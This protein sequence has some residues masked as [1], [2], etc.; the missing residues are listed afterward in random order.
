MKNK[1]WSIQTL[2][3]RLKNYKLLLLKAKTEEDKLNI[4]KTIKSYEQFIS[5]LTVPYQSYNYQ[6]IK[7]LDNAKKNE[8]VETLPIIIEAN[9]F[10]L[11]EN[12]LLPSELFSINTS[13]ENILKVTRSFY[14]TI[15]SIYKELYDEYYD[16]NAIYINFFNNY[17][18]S[19]CGNI[20]RP[21]GAKEC[22]ININMFNNPYD[23]AT[24][25]HEHSHAIAA[26]IYEDHID[27]PFLNE[28]ESILFELIYLDTLD[29]SEYKPE[30]IKNVKDVTI[31]MYNRTLNSIDS[32]NIT[33][34]KNV[35]DVVRAKRIIQEKYS[36]DESLSNDI[37]NTPL[38]N[39]INY[40]LSYLIAIE[41]FYIYK[42]C[43]I[44][45]LNILEEIIRIDSDEEDIILKYLQDLGIIPGNNFKRFFKDYL[46]IKGTKL[47]I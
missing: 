41:L 23:I 20:I 12:L 7:K 47:S 2:K 44:K 43:D 11:S 6:Y 33:T 38:S 31:G 9:N 15:G 46:N 45:A 5:E 13:K 26:S 14:T 10:L 8:Y 16:T 39:Y 42:R 34:L 25:I 29:K 22:F 4:I 3:D 27:N 18:N 28:V 24:S 1:T 37:I 32:K 17:D 19:L 36:I 35:K 40:G 21:R 30:Q